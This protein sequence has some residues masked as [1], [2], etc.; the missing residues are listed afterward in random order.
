MATFHLCTSELRKS[1]ARE[2]GIAAAQ[3]AEIA[4]FG[5]Q[6][7]LAGQRSDRADYGFDFG[8]LGHLGNLDVDVAVFHF[9]LK[10]RHRF[11]GVVIVLAGGA[12]ELPEV[13]GADHAAIV[14]L[15]LT[16]RAAAMDAD[17][18]ESADGPAGMAHGIGLT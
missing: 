1:V 6:D 4:K 13:V 18:A 17:A 7:A 11:G 2:V 8:E 16:E 5:I 12:I 9:D 3:D 10:N 14:D 15:P